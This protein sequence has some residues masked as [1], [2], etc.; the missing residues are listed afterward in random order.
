MRHWLAA[1]VLVTVGAGCATHSDPT[2]SPEAF[3]TRRPAIGRESNEPIDR[4]G[5]LT[6][7]AQHVPEHMAADG[8]PISPVVRDH[9]RN[10]DRIE[11]PAAA[12][13]PSTESVAS[14]QS[15]GVISEPTTGPTGVSTATF[16][17]VGAVVAEVNGQPIYADKVLARLERALS[18]E[19]KHRD[20]SSFRVLADELVH[21]EIA[22]LVRDEL[23]FAAA[24]KSL[25]KNDKELAK[26]LTVDWRRKQI[27]AAG[28]AEAEARARF[29]AQGQNFEEA[30][31]EEYR[32]LVF[33]IYLQRK[34][35]PLVQ[36]SADDIR[37][38]Y[39]DHIRDFTVAAAAKFRVIKID[40]QK[41]GE[42][43]AMAK[44]REVA[45]RAQGGDDFAALA[46]QFNDDPILQGNKGAVGENGWME[47]GAYVNEKLEQAVWQL[48]PRQITPI[49]QIG[50]YIY[51]AKLEDIRDGKARTFEDAQVQEAI[52]QK[53]RGEQ[54]SKLTRKQ[55]EDLE[56]NAVIVPKIG[57]DKVAVDMVMQ[58]YPLWASAK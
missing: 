14:I 49:M 15:A 45:Q 8:Q 39:Q 44:A 54:L 43:A 19:A 33:E 11:I 38:Y 16:Q 10:A 1:A 29:A 4:P 32:H 3:V 12:T 50:D 42:N 35:L 7:D 25:D 30:A 47:K 40:I 13:R 37:H 6:Y 51:I 52:E 5:A 27:T 20:L 55:T 23:Q 41:N 21:Q 22:Y 46:A 26:N 56:K 2:L 9:V 57:M 53:L 36:V 24:E 28:G 31:R 58:R 48:K 34:I 18:S 17:Y